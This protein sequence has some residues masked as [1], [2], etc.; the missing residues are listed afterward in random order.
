MRVASIRG[1]W[2]PAWAAARTTPSSLTHQNAHPLVWLSGW[3]N[4]AAAVQLSHALSSHARINETGRFG[5]WSAELHE[6]ID[7]SPFTGLAKS[8]AGDLA[9]GSG[10]T[11]IGN[12]DPRAVPVGLMV[13][14]PRSNA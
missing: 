1:T 14:M 11:N 7:A 8:V 5:T 13:P 4:F 12:G 2:E 3:R 9:T 6:R 10:L